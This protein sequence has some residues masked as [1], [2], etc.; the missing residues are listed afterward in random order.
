MRLDLV[1]NLTIL[2]WNWTNHIDSIRK[3]SIRS[4]DVCFFLLHSVSL[5]WYRWLILSLINLPGG[6]LWI[7]MNWMKWISFIEWVG[8]GHIGGGFQHFL[9]ELLLYLLLCNVNTPFP[10]W[11]ENKEKRPFNSSTSTFPPSHLHFTRLHNN[12]TLSKQIIGSILHLLV[13]P[14]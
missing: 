10:C 14:F 1:S 3:S 6:M 5:N 4:I 8:R 2:M 11:P 12:A 9:S 7:S 13:F